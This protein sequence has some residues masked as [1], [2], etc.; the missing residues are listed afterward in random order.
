MQNSIKKTGYKRIQFLDYQKYVKVA[1]SVYVN[2][3]YV[4]EHVGSINSY[5]NLTPDIFKNLIDD[6]AIE[7]AFWANIG[8]FEVP[9]A[10]GVSDSV[11]KQSAKTVWNTNRIESHLKQLCIYHAKDG[12]SVHHFDGISNPY[13]YYGVASTT[14]GLH[15]EDLGMPS[16]N[17]NLGSIE[18]FIEFI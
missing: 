13:I 11:F 5:Q 14:F 16:V 6:D 9:Y 1:D 12:N 4:K 7:Q 8:E 17:Y 18:S 3:G 10:S 2:Q 15:I